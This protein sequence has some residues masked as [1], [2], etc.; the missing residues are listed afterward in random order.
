MLRPPESARSMRRHARAFLG[1][2]LALAVTACASGGDSPASRARTLVR[3]LEGHPQA[4]KLTCE[5]R[6]AADLL[7]VY[8]LPGGEEDVFARLPRSENPDLGFVG[9]PNGEPGQLPPAPYGVHAEPV[10][11]A[12]RSMG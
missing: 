1:L 7:A 12:L 2:S 3:R 9:D 5:S 10:A 11:A 6:S 4:K 8:G